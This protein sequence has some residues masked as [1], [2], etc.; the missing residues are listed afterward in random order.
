MKIK[1]S[2]PV[3]ALYFFLLAGGLWHILDMFQ[4]VMQTAAPLIM[5]FLSVW[6]FISALFSIEE[7]RK[8]RR[9]I[10]WSAGII[11]LSLLVEIAGVQTG[12]IFGNYDYGKA[13]KPFVGGAPLVIGFAWFNM[14]MGSLALINNFASDKLKKSAVLTALAAAFLMVVFDM[15]MEPAA[16]KLDYWSWE[17]GIIP[18]Q[19][20]MAWFVCG[21]AFLYAGVRFKIVNGK[22][23]KIAYHVYFA[24]L[25]YFLIIIIGK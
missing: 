9:F 15:I 19:N 2:W 1:I 16:V 5:A 6:I 12:V 20:Y 23:P 4:G 25:A 10:W 18:L 11:I 21:F 17:N 22:I 14:V 3:T 13:L 7:I 8:K 24:Q